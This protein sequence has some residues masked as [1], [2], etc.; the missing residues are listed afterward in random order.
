MHMHMHMHIHMRKQESLEIAFVDSS[1]NM[2][3]YNLKVFLIVITLPLAI[4]IT[5]DEKTHTFIDASLL[6]KSCFTKYYFH[7]R[8]PDRPIVTRGALSRMFP[9]ETFFMHFSSFVASMEV[10]M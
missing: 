7:D 2:E 5:S 8:A 9:F 4:L 10:V 6:L 3:E 1:L